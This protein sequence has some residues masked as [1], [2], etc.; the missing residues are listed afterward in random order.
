MKT[1]QIEAFTGFTPLGISPKK[2]GRYAGYHRFID[3]EGYGYGS[4]EVFWVDQWEESDTNSEPGWY[5]WPCFP[6]CLPDTD[7]V[8]PFDTAKQAFDN[9]R[10][11]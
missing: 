1:P 4:F 9:A 11:N 6:G 8:G 5:W 7:A 10:G 2:A 3:D